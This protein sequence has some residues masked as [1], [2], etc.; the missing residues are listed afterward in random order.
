MA[1]LKGVLTAMVTPFAEDGAWTRG[2]PAPCAQLLENGS[3]GLVV[4]GTTGES[5]TL[6][7]EEEVALLSA[8]RG[9]VGGD[10]RWS[11]APAR[12]TRATPST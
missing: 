12:T 10:D 5:P 8:V 11:A 9:E 6:S 4:A 3:H 1:E 7:D 2:P